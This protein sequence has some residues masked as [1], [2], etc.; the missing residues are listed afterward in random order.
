MSQPLP[1][2]LCPLNT[3]GSQ[4]DSCLWMVPLCWP[5][6]R[7]RWVRCTL[8]SPSSYRHFLPL[9][10]LPAHAGVCCHTWRHHRRGPAFSHWSV[11]C[12]PQPCFPVAVATII[13]PECCTAGCESPLVPCLSS[14]SLLRPSCSL[15]GPELPQGPVCSSP[16]LGSQQS[17][18]LVAE[19]QR[20]C[21]SL[22]EASGTSLPSPHCPHPPPHVPKTPSYSATL[23]RTIA[24]LPGPRQPFLAHSQ[25]PTDPA[26]SGP[27]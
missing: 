23:L 17:I 16:A 21:S 25:Q 8:R 7:T 19:G 2:F 11:P 18:S 6:L 24:S 13:G 26:L 9:G 5:H 4:D 15:P 14:R 27:P 20:T 1:E 22:D 3:P 10:L 12:A